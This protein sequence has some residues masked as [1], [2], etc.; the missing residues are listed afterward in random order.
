MP[1]KLSDRL[2]FLIEYLDLAAA[3]DDPQAR[4]EPYQMA[5]L[6]DDGL[7][8]IDTKSRQVGWSWTAAAGAVADSILTGRATNVFVSI[9]QEEAREKIRYARYILEALDPEV[10]PRVII[11]NQQEL[12]IDNGS[13]LISHPCRPV[14][15]KAKINVYLD[16]FAHYPKDREIYTSALPATTRG[17]RLRIGSSPLGAGGQFWEI[18]TQQIQTYPG[19]RRG[20]VPWWLVSSTCRDVDEARRLAPHMTTEERV[21]A[22]GGERLITIFENMPLEDFQQEYECAWVDESVAWITWDEI[23]RNQVLAQG[24]GLTCW[25][26]ESVDEALA[27]IDQ[28]AE[29]Q[30]DGRIEGVLCGGMDVGRKRNLSEIVFVGKGTTNQLPFRLM[31]SLA[32]VEFDDQKAVVEKALTTLRC[33]KFLIDRNGLGMQL[34]ESLEKRFPTKVEGVDFTNA[35]KELWAVELKVR[36]QRAEVPLPLVRELTYQV[37]SIKK[38]IS[39]AKNAIFD[40]EANE[41]HHADKFWALALAV[42]AAG[43]PRGEEPALPMPSVPV[44]GAS[45]PE[46]QKGKREDRKKRRRSKGFGLSGKIG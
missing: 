39:A 8:G 16:E 28:V 19:Y 24:G 45:R 26:V 5:A 25:M 18:Y 34:A 41:K 22:F 2:T 46:G 20:F 42:W 15:G 21:R 29:A 4:W 32:Q 30:A 36:V 10:R 31:I 27:V 9:N 33:P 11:E 38:K 43:G 35:S 40:T 23:K 12:E 1:P 13:R 6:N 14:R 3:T 44:R 17:G 7:L 37:H